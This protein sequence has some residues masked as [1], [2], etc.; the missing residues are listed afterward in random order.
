ML[1]VYCVSASN[2]P[3][4][5][6][7]ASP[8]RVLDLGSDVLYHPCNIPS[9]KESKSQGQSRFKIWKTTPPF[10]GRKNNIIL[11]NGHSQV[12]K[13]IIAANLC[14]QPT[15]SHKCSYVVFSLSEYF[16]IF[17][18]I[19]FLIM[20]CLEYMFLNLKILQYF[21]VISPDGFVIKFLCGQRTY[22]VQF[23]FF[24]I[25]RLVSWPCI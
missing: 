12:T 19:F 4:I 7:D 13:G 21:L 22:V 8:G 18:L 3:L 23:Q 2:S 5:L 14:K 1:G 25:Y 16:P 20:L 24:E 9:V 15:T 6:K 10:D 17:L 11:Q